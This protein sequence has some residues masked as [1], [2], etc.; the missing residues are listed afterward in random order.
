MFNDHLLTSLKLILQKFSIYSMFYWSFSKKVLF[1]YTIEKNFVW[2]TANYAD[3]YWFQLDSKM[4]NL[5]YTTL[6][7]L[8]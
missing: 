7:N 6:P 8:K 4:S 5:D 3:S 1:K 2:K